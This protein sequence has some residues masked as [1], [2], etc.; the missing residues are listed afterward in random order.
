MLHQMGHEVV[1]AK[2]GEETLRLYKEAMDSDTPVNLIIMDLTIPGGMGGKEAVQKILAINPEAKV[3]VS[4]GY[5]N[6][7]VMANFK[8]Y[9]FCAAVAKPFRL[10]EL[11]KIIGQLLD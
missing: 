9:G 3:I 10:A 2:D 5:S 7:T 4:S 1:F 8:D 6:D 11:R